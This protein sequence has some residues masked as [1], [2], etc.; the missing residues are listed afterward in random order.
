MFLYISL[1]NNKMGILI[2]ITSLARCV[3]IKFNVYKA[4]EHCL[5]YSKHL[6]VCCYHYWFLRIVWIVWGKVKWRD[7]L[8]Y[9]NSWLSFLHNTNVFMSKSLWGPGSK[10]NFL[11][12]YNPLYTGDFSLTK[13]KRI[14][15]CLY[16]FCVSEMCLYFLFEDSPSLFTLLFGSS[17]FYSFC[18]ILIEL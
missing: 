9:I 3:K 12:H 17:M 2:T 14:S 15:G 5:S 13:S 6:R 18:I 11:L 7:Q 4:L 8:I 1:L 16:I 10:I